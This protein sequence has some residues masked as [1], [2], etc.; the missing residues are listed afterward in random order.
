MN[1]K[2]DLKH[3]IAYLLNGWWV[4]WIIILLVT[5]GKWDLWLTGFRLS[6]LFLPWLIYYGWWVAKIP[7]KPTPQQLERRK[8]IWE[9]VVTT[10][11]LTC[12]IVLVWQVIIYLS[13][14][15]TSTLR[16][17]GWILGL[18]LVGVIIWYLVSKIILWI[19]RGLRRWAVDIISDAIKKSKE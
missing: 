7:T 6:Q 18:G 2:F 11:W 13:S 17:I 10:V 1:S 9:I 14:L 15:E 8:A 12:L 19:L 4:L 5:G 3:I 16:G